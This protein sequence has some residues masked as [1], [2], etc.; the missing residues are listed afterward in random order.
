MKFVFRPVLALATLSALLVLCS[1]GAWQLRRLEWKRDLIARVDARVGSAPIPL[2]SALARAA[3]G[4]DLDYQP[5]RVVGVFDHARE[6]CVFGTFEGRAGCYVFTPIGEGE[7]RIVYVNRGFVPQN[8]DLSEIEDPSG[9]VTVVGLLRRAET[10]A[11][12]Q[13]L[14]RAKDQPKDNI[15]FVRDPR[16]FA[17]ADGLAG[18][19]YIDS[20]GAESEGRWPK[21]GTTRLEFSNRHLEYALTWFGLAVT[22]AGV[23]LAYSRRKA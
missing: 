16:A 23:F 14:F 18:P 4:E 21:G 11:G 3:A 8:A 22:L 2:Q 12:L 15:Y 17:G 9:P 13:R 6:A 1:L 19:Y 20:N 7:G 5:V 10:P